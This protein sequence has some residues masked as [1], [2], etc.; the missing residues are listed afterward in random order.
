MAPD[1]WTAPPGSPG[2]ETLLPIMLS[3]GVNKGR[4]SLE[5]LVEVL[6]Q[7]SAKVFNIYPQKGTIQIGSDADLVIIDLEKKATLGAD[8]QH[9][10]LSDYSPYEGMEVK[11]LPI[12]TMVRGQVVVED[13]EMVGEPGW[14]KYIYRS[15]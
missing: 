5:K 8:R 4:M 10:K 7:N 11:G 2:A 3:E 13:G 14:G 12:L 15:C 9:Y 6:C 1:L